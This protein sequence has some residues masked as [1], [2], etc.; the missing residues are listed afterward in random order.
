MC[1][2]V[3]MYLC[4]YVYVCMR[5]ADKRS[6]KTLYAGTLVSRKGADICFY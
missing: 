1:I 4:T 3:G 5:K 2:Y 6:P